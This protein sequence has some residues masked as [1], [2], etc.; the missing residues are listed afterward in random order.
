M[1]FYDE[2][3]G[4]ADAEKNRTDAEDRLDAV[5]TRQRELDGDSPFHFD[6]H[7]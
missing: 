3:R 7:F 4:Y 6:I 1:N 2:I 5:V